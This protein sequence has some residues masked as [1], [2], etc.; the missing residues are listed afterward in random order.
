MS[1]FEWL[2]D[3]VLRAVGAFARRSAALDRAALVISSAS[4]LKGGVTAAFFWG[5]WHAGPG[6]SPGPDRLTPHGSLPNPDR[7]RRRLLAT[8]IACCVATAG[9]R[10][11]GEALPFRERPVHA[12]PAGFARPFSM[13]G[14]PVLEEATSL[15]SDHAI[16]FCGLA[17]GL[18]LANRRAG[19][20]AAAWVAGAV[21]LPRLFLGLHYATDVLAGAALGGAA[22]AAGVAAADRRGPARRGLDRVLAWGRARPG[23]FAGL[24]FL[25]TFEMATLF[26]TGRRA[27]KMLAAL[28]GG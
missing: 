1:P 14:N 11:L 19:A 13:D 6:R 18:F 22:V 8:L 20:W 23:P 5:V 16:L 25:A 10:V 27:L 4:L 7:A 21:L 3:A 2:D 9:G 17:A 26:G 28:L 12:G 15:P 24:L